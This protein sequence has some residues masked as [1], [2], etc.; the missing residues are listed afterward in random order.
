MTTI[1]TMYYLCLMRP[2]GKIN[3]QRSHNTKET[4]FSAAFWD[5][6]LCPGEKLKLWRGISRDDHRYVIKC[7]VGIIYHV[8]V[9]L[10][11]LKIHSGYW[12]MWPWY[13]PGVFQVSQEKGMREK[14]QLQRKWRKTAQGWRRKAQRWQVSF[15]K[16]WSDCV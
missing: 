6:R 15:L 8:L 12:T 2:K 4:C 16:I 1:P 11:A 10:E 9:L 13:R 5:K 7:V 3:T 14:I